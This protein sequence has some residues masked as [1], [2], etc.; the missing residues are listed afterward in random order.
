[1]LWFSL[2][3]VWKSDDFLFSADVWI[4]ILVIYTTSVGVLVIM[5]LWYNGKIIPLSRRNAK[6]A[7]V[8]VFLYWLHRTI[9]FHHNAHT[10]TC[11]TVGD[12]Y[13]TDCVIKPFW[14]YFSV[15]LMDSDNWHTILLSFFGKILHDIWK[16]LLIFSWKN[17]VSVQPQTVVSFSGAL[18]SVEIYHNDFS[19]NCQTTTEPC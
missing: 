18:T 11:I 16:F 1:M 12:V 6:A 5:I 2:T 9:D 10:Y 3:F 7:L 17:G 8:A 4:S 14:M 15:C 13:Y 19:P